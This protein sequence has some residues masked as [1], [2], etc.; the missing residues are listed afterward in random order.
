MFKKHLK[1]YIW[2]TRDTNGLFFTAYEY[3]NRELSRPEGLMRRVKPLLRLETPTRAPVC[4]VTSAEVLQQT[5]TITSPDIK[6][7]FLSPL[8]SYQLMSSLLLRNHI[9]KLKVSKGSQNRKFKIKFS[10]GV[11]NLVNMILL[12]MGNEIINAISLWEFQSW[13]SHNNSTVT[14]ILEYSSE[15]DE[16]MCVFTQKHLCCILNQAEFYALLIA[17]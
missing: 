9:I 10:Q 16:S 15:V 5:I 4:T 14:Q 6:L 3:P 8:I 11:R 2:N 12:R 7:P 1:Q 13:D 17:V